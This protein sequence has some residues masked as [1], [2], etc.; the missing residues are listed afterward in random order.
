MSAPLASTGARRRGFTLVETMIAFVLS[1]AVLYTVYSMAGFGTRTAARGQARA[2]AV[3]STS[4]ALLKIM[5]RLRYT[6]QVTLPVSG[7]MGEVLE[8]RGVS[9]GTWR[10]TLEDR[11]VVLRQAFGSEEETLARGVDF[12]R[13]SR[14]PSLGQYVLRV[15]LGVAKRGGMKKFSTTDLEKYSTA[16]YLR[17]TRR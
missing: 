9:R 4:G 12:L 7:E 1:T 14:D 17:G 16:V 6:D 8:F 3:D 5:K 11:K 10:V 2:G 15:E 13:F